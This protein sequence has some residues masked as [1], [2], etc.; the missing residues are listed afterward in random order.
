MDISDIVQGLAAGAGID[1][2]PDGKTAYYVERNSGEL[3]KVTVETGEVTTILGRFDH[4]EDVVIDRETEEMFV[5]EQ[6]GGIIRVS[7]K[8][9]TPIL[10]LSGAPHQLALVKKEGKRYLYTV[11]CQGGTLIRIDPDT[12]KWTTVTA[13]LG[14]PVGLVVDP[15]SKYAYLT[16]ERTSLTRIDLSNGKKE[17]LYQR[18][19]NPFFLAWDKHYKHIFCVQ[20]DPH[21]LVR[22]NL[23]TPLMRE[24]I[25]DRL[26][27]YPSGVAPNSDDTKIYICADRKLQVISS[28]RVLPIAPPSPPFEVYSI[29]FC[30]EGSGA[31]PLKDYKT[32]DFIDPEYVKGYRNEPAAYVRGTWPAI[33]VVFCKLHYFEGKYAVSA[34]GNLGGVQRKRIELN[35]NSAGHSDPIDFQLMFP[36][37]DTIG[38]HTVSLEWYARPTGRPAVLIPISSTEHTLCT[39]WKRPKANVNEGLTTWVYKD[40]MLWTSE[41][42]AGKDNEKDICDAIIK[43]LHLSG[44]KY[45]I[46]KS[47]KDSS[48]SKNGISKP[49][50][51]IGLW[52]VPGMLHEGGGMCG[53]WYQMFQHLAHC[54]GV[55]VHRR[56]YLVDWR[57]LPHDEVMWCAI[58]ITD[59]GLNQPEPTFRPAEFHDVDALYPIVSNTPLHTCTERRYY[60][61]GRRGKHWDGHA[62]NF[63]EYEGN[64]YLYDPS[65]GLGPFEIDMSLPPGDLTILGGKQLASFKANYLNSV[66][67]YML[68][69]LLYKGQLQK[70]CVKTLIIPDV[71]GSFQEITFY[72]IK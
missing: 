27:W 18:L 38:T 66:V 13:G 59:G 19:K 28:D 64:L 29:Q 60:F 49:K 40:L 51:G 33:K 57:E 4:P 22:L 35:F 25:T 43:N 67:D 21:S 10:N 70:I 68:G 53:G 50:H 46:F 58:V 41:W 11:C 3:C 17:I 12:E 69:I 37:P 14:H 34:V 39:T 24:T 15:E 9:Q 65:F 55:F 26:A 44:L 6:T 72:W 61:K 56:C 5:S 8:K 31:I 30:Y 2:S 16:E 23:G 52:S 36:L 62:I 47:K 1:L 7:D 42:A 71:V 20:R 54:Q 63:L 32:N 48:E 45:G